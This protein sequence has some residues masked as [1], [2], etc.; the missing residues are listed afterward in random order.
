[1][2]THLPADFTVGLS[3]FGMELMCIRL[4]GEAQM[5]NEPYTPNPCEQCGPQNP[6]PAPGN[7]SNVKP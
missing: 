4:C 6:N 1:M 2:R 7:T 3:L 5:I